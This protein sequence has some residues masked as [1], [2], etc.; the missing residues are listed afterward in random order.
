MRSSL[1]AATSRGGR[2]LPACAPLS[3][4][5]SAAL[6]A[7]ATS[8]GA[9]PAPA[10]GTPEPSLVYTVKRSDKLIRLSK[11]LLVRPAAWPE[12]AR[13]NKLKDPNVISPGQ[14]LNVP[15][16]LLKSQPAAAR[17]VSIE[18]DVQVGGGAATT[19][20]AVAEGGKLQTGANSSAVLEL[21]DGTR[22]KVLPN[23][24]AEVV[25]NRNYAMRDPA[26]SATT[27]WYSGLVRLAQGTLETL[28]AK[29]AQR[30]T[31]LN[32]ETPTSLV[33]VRGT[34]FRVAYEDPASRNARTE[35]VEGL[36]R[37]DNP[38]QASGADLPAGT[39]AVIN[40]AQ[41]EIKVVQLLPAPDLAA[42]PADLFKPQAALA[43]PV[44]AGASAFRI[45]VASDAQFDR[46]V[47]DLKIAGQSVELGSLASG[48][49]Y[50]RLRGIDA[51]GL[52]GLDTVRLVAV[53][54][55]LPTAWRVIT[56]SLSLADGKAVLA[57][58]A[59]QANGQPLAVAPVTA[60]LASDI[61]F[62]TIIERPN[63]EGQSMV[64]G[65][66]KPGEYFIRL[67]TRGT[68]G[69]VIDS[70]TYRFELPENWGST[71][72]GVTFALE[73]VR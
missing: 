9:Q 50:A 67:H 44:L 8:V 10:P 61:D 16:R 54:D 41:K 32:V 11:D 12:V 71:V 1:S 21:G 39:G 2:F 70:E 14:K 48:N 22:V 53:K 30:A 15:L 31:P 36:V 5:V 17:L 49:W 57:W 26:S 59:Q 63:A 35:V 60:E 43:L 4:L 40:P 7:L 72:F 47:R 18:G 19:G 33:G 62:K 13:F 69:A 42:W 34:Q 68:A 28:A 51:Q 52:E 27:N 38:A 3:V 64:L 46:I 56:S 29:I 20:Q 73:K 6:L 55:A 24:L 37:A 58:T 45:Q 65:A 25:T 66:L 23:S